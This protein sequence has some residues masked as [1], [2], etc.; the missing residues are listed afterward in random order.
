MYRRKCRR[1]RLLEGRSRSSYSEVSAFDVAED[2]LEQ[3]RFEPRMGC[4]IPPGPS[5]GNRIVGAQLFA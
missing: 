2:R 5:G 3:T 4:L 1:R